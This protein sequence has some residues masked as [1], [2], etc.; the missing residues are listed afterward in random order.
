VWKSRHERKKWLERFGAAIAIGNAAIIRRPTRAAA[1]KHTSHDQRRRLEAAGHVASRTSP[2]TPTQSAR[3]RVQRAPFPRKPEFF[4]PAEGGRR[5]QPNAFVQAWHSVFSVATTQPHSRLHTDADD[6]RSSPTSSRKTRK[7]REM[8]NWSPDTWLPL[9]YAGIDAWGGNVGEPSYPEGQHLTAGDTGD[10][11]ECAGFNAAASHLFKGAQPDG[12]CG[13][14]ALAFLRAALRALQD[15]GFSGLSSL[16]FKAMLPTAV[17]M[18]SVHELSEA[19]GNGRTVP[20]DALKVDWLGAAD[21][22][23]IQ[24]HPI[25]RQELTRATE[26]CRGTCLRLWHAMSGAAFLA[27]ERNPH[28][29]ESCNGRSHI[30]VPVQAEGP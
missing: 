22:N 30:P 1:A 19:L 13:Y 17:S 2:A 15:D 21:I 26:K 14:V 3:S 10:I 6:K 7:W 16:N 25:V 11:L 9:G 12:A 18:N 8:L 24:A 20:M 27:R 29:P 23:A 28:A 5:K 4:D